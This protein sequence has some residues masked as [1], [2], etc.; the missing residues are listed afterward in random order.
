MSLQ[1]EYTVGYIILFFSPDSVI[2]IGG[3]VDLQTSDFAHTAGIYFRLALKVNAKIL[4]KQQW[5]E[6]NDLTQWKKTE[7]PSLYRKLPHRSFLIIL[8]NLLDLF[9]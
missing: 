9:D 6:S 1:Q 5:A 4:W 7:F 8:R 3:A 2:F